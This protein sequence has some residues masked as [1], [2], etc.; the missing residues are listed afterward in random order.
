MLKDIRQGSDS[1]FPFALTGL[2]NLVLF[3]SNDYTHGNELWRTDG[4]SNGTVLVKDIYCGLTSSGI[5]SLAVLGSYVYFGAA[6]YGCSD[7]WTGDE[8]WRSDGT[9]NGTTEVTN[10]GNG[11]GTGIYPSMMFSY[12]D[13]L[14][15]RSETGT[16]GQELWTSDG[17]S[18]GTSLHTD[19]RIGS[20]GSAPR[21]FFAAGS[22]VYFISTAYTGDEMYRVYAN[23]SWEGLLSSE[24]IYPGPNSGSPDDFVVAGNLI[25]FTATDGVNGRELWSIPLD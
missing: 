18:T 4:T 25:F 10:F 15:F 13:T 1:S 5:D 20:S 23:L 21:G 17:T 2:G 24:D 19:I 16:T 6:G 8:L 9:S 22:T 14:F 3:V 11:Y 12:N 7:D